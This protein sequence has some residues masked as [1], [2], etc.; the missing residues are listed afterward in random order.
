MTLSRRHFVAGTALLAAA[1]LPVTAL[2]QTYPAYPIRIVVGYPPATAPDVLAR[3]LAQRMAELLKQQVVVD[4]K[5]GAGGQIAAQT[6]A[7]AQ[8]DGYTLLLGEVGSIAIAPPA[9]SKLQYDPARELT[10]VSEVGKVDLL[11]AV[12]ANSP[13]QTV[14]DFVKAAKA[15]GDKINF[16]TFGAG[17][18]GHFGAE[19][20]AEAAGFKI[21]PVHYRNTGDAVTGIINGDV[22]GAF[23][24][25]ALGAAQIKGGKMRAL[26]TSAPVRSPLLPQV[27]TMI[28]AGYPKMDVSAWF[29]LMAPAATP[30]AVLDLLARE[31]AAAV[32]S[33]DTKAKIVEAGFSV[34][35]LSRADTDRML[36]AEYPRWAGIVKASGFRGD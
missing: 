4:N 1:Q 11:L 24:S 23:V 33:P 26:A 6:V 34:T 12:P 29:A 31:A 30:P 20:F 18:P 25:T 21:E 36:R 13:H 3:F 16:G 15:R 10:G 22:A 8:P 5:P 27:P 19:V 32:Q 2:A 35:G 7:K 9:F 17:S 14:A 28:E